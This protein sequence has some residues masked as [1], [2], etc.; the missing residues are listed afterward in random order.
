MQ[1]TPSARILRMLGE[2]EIEEWKCLAEL[3]DNAFDDFNGIIASD[4]RWAGGMKVSVTLPKSNARPADAEIVVRDSGRGMTRERLADAVRAGWSSNNQ[5]DKLGLFGMGFNVSTA[6]LGR[7]TRVLTTR[8]GDPQWI[9]VE[10]DLDEIGDDFEAPD[11][12]EPK[13]DPSE[14]GTK[15]EISRLDPAR[16][17]WLA[18]NG[19]AL[20]AQFGR[21]YG[22]LLEHRPFELWVAG[23]EVKPRRHCAW[24]KN[25]S[26]TYGSGSRA[27]QIPAVI[28]I[29]EPYSLADACM[30]CGHWQQQGLDECENCGKPEHLKPRARRM[31]GWVGIQRYLDNDEFGIDFLRNGR[32]ILTNYKDIFQWT[33]IN[34][35]TSRVIREYPIELGQG[36]RIVGEIHLD[37]VRVDYKKDTFDKSDP[38]WRRAIEYLR[39]RGPM[40]PEKAKDLGWHE[41]NNS[42]LARLHRGFRRNDPGK[43]Y[44]IPGDGQKAVHS[45]AWR[46][47]Q[48]FHKG[49]AEY[50]TDEK[51]WEQVL[52]HERRKAEAA[53][54]KPDPSEGGSV[55][56]TAVDDALGLDESNDGS[57]A[58]GAAPA[59]PAEPPAPKPETDQQRIARYKEEGRPIAELAG[60][61][62]HPDL[63]F[64]KV[65]ALSLGQRLLDANGKETAARVVPGSGGSATAFVNR[66]H[67]LFVR[68]G[69]SYEDAI[70]TELA[71]LLRAR[72]GSDLS[73]SEIISMVKEK[74]MQDTAIDVRTIKTQAEDLLGEVRNRMASEIEDE[75]ERAFQYLTDDELV[76][77]ENAMIAS[78]SRGSGPMDEAPFV[79]YAPSLF[80]VRLVEEM[81]EMFLDGKVFRS[82]YDGVTSAA[83]KRQ[84][85]SQV[86]S[87]L[88]DVA[89]L[90]QQYDPGELRLKRTRLSMQLLLDELAPER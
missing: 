86:T 85:V 9:G 40:L 77:T 54:P 23:V 83:G 41:P 76:A 89:A 18:R 73:A 30:D 43:R 69:W 63:G 46:W 60:D 22:W 4:I 36:G 68:F 72:A 6:R 59:P 12:V 15:I 2:I 55:D 51:W 34:D 26:V 49:T 25:R 84:S 74:S 82:P 61:L 78:G 33:D 14:H 27:E 64:M 21:V 37:H 48:E 75:P 39:G 88:A 7:K 52:E 10:I 65:E 58:P 1:I 11:I 80:L 19:K 50:Q 3:I 16:L 56:E 62:G 31:H 90:A 32:K 42:P 81:P 45:T 35:P 20:R 44:L 47:G 28:E 66:R 24:D 71:G 67:A 70:V 17:D 57:G 38:Q 79:R 29:D 13:N 5:F 87:L 53:R 8:A